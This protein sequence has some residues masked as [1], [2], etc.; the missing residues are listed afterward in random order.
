M[1]ANSN[2]YSNEPASFMNGSF[3][4]LARVFPLGRLVYSTKFYCFC[5]RNGNQT[6]ALFLMIICTK[7]ERIL[8]SLW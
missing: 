7:K 8:F 4:K 5:A 3:K 6:I 1:D 2:F